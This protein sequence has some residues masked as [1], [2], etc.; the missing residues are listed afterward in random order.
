[1]SEALQE[2]LARWEELANEATPGPWIS[3]KRCVNFA[4]RNKRA[5]YVAHEGF[6]VSGEYVPAA[7]HL[8]DLSKAD[9][10][11]DYIAH[12][13]PAFALDL[14]QKVRAAL[15]PA[16]GSGV[17]ERPSRIGGS[18]RPHY[19]AYVAEKHFDKLEAMIAD[20]QAQLKGSGK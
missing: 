9:G 1:M 10:T 8:S 19:N 13:N 14:I 11:A 2:E 16:P 12:S 15:Q 18:Y 4:A 3:S 6:S 5:G 20:L 17:P 7:G